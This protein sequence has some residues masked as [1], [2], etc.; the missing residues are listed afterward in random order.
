MKTIQEKIKYAT[1]KLN[2]RYKPRLYARSVI[3]PEFYD[4]C[5]V[6]RILVLQIQQTF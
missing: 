5:H 6:Q 3:I 2:W 4:F 1:K